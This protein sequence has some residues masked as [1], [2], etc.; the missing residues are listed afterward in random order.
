MFRTQFDQ[1]QTTSCNILLNKRSRFKARLTL[2]CVTRFCLFSV[3][4]GEE[5]VCWLLTEGGLLHISLPWNKQASH[6]TEK[7]QISEE[8]CAHRGW[9][10]W[11]RWGSRLCGKDEWQLQLKLHEDENRRESTARFKTHLST[12]QMPQ[13]SYMGFKCLL[14]QWSRTYCTLGFGFNTYS[15]DHDAPCVLKLA[16]SYKIQ[17]C[18]HIVAY[19]RASAARRRRYDVNTFGKK[20]FVNTFRINALLM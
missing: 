1:I 2:G 6:S 4:R 14:K 7:E 8:S 17:I 5:G 16:Q 9:V 18:G 20:Q 10:R 19:F 3:S 12:Q 11:W 15:K 13:W